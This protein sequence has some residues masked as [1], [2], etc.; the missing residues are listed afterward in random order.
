MGGTP[1]ST[2]RQL[3]TPLTIGLNAIGSREWVGGAELIK[4]LVIATSRYCQS[5]GLAVRFRIIGPKPSAITAGVEGIDD[6]QWIDC[7]SPTTFYGRILRHAR[8]AQLVRRENIDFLY[9]SARA[10]GCRSAAWIADFQHKYLPDFYSE[11]E[12]AFRDRSFR[13]L[14]NG[15]SPVVL[16]SESAKSDLKR[17][18]PLHT[19]PS[20]VLSFRVHIPEA[21]VESALHGTV[22]KYNLP[23]KYF[24]V[25]NQFWR[26]KNHIVVLDALERCVTAHPDLTVAITGRINDDRSPEYADEILAFIQ[27]RGIHKNCRL[28]GLIPKED[29]IHLLRGSHAV[30]Q[31]SFFEGWSTIVEE[32]HA[33]GKRILL[34]D[35]PVHREQDPPKASYFQPTNAE[36]LARLMCNHWSIHANEQIDLNYAAKFAEFGK[37]FYDIASG[38]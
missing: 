34:S 15:S 17:F 27:T 19:R 21:W 10:I 32:A 28:L 23:N 18:F 16:S 3:R 22:Q 38:I 2:I 14:S 33:L 31:P 9:P 11:H 25:C 12:I 13:R 1:P 35:L 30:I 29:Q 6:V 37:Q 26:H 20:R 8:I 4:N 24:I 7:P 36:Q 5:Q